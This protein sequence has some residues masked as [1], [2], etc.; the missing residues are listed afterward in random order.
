MTIQANVCLVKNLEVFVEQ[1]GY[2]LKDVAHIDN[3]YDYLG[4][5][6]L[7]PFIAEIQPLLEA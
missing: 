4:Q 3:E 7:P 6:D 1:V 5:R 2:S